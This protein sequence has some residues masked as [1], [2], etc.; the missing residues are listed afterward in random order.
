MALI[1][2]RNGDGGPWIFRAMGPASVVGAVVSFLCVTLS[3]K[4]SYGGKWK[5]TVE[6]SIVHVKSSVTP[7]WVGWAAQLGPRS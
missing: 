6:E 2:S 3:F 5:P 1:K 7:S 4:T